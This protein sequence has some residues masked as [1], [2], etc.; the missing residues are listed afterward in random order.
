MGEG[1]VV[2]FD[3]PVGLKSQH[4]FEFN[5][6]GVVTADAEFGGAGQHSVAF[7]AFDGL[8]SERYINGPQA[9]AAVRGPADNCF[10]SIAFRGNHGFDILAERLDGDDAGF[11]RLGQQRAGFF[12]AF[13]FR[14]LEGD[15]M[16]QLLGRL[17]D[18][19]DHLTQPGVG[20]FHALN[21]PKT[22]K[23][24]PFS[25]RISSIS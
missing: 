13:T 5:D 12:E 17:M 20:E 7:Y 2:D 10:Y 24:P 23:S 8:F 14:R 15:E 4:F 19:V 9:G 3:Y 16:H 11:A 6:A 21:W 25:N 1:F 18:A 22:R